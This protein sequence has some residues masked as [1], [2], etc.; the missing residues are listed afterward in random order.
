[1]L[2]KL[3][4]RRVGVSRWWYDNDVCSSQD[5]RCQTQE[6]SSYYWKFLSWSQKCL[7]HVDCRFIGIWMRPKERKE[8][9]A[10]VKQHLR[11]VL[12]PMFIGRHELTVGWCWQQWGHEGSGTRWWQMSASL[13]RRIP[14]YALSSP[15]STT[16]D[17]RR[18]VSVAMNVSITNWMTSPRL[19]EVHMH[20]SKPL[21][22][23]QA[24]AVLGWRSSANWVH[25]WNNVVFS[26]CDRR[27]H[28][29]DNL[30]GGR[31]QLLFATDLPPARQ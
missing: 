25:K 8:L 22:Q 4:K 11:V 10:Y 13:N 15:Q 9:Q 18:V 16:G 28:I 19:H 6:E 14:R 23:L 2:Y 27:V 29:C 31:I 3:A 21:R 26:A 17:I 7:V 24:I 30:A 5:K 20:S 1:M 12:L